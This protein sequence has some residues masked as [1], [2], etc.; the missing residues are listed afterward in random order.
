MDKAKLLSKA[1]LQTAF[2]M[3][4][5]DKSGSISATEL[6]AMLGTEAMNSEEW[7]DIIAEVDKNG[8]GEIDVKEF[9]AI[10]LNKC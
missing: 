1:N 4:D 3:F 10:L 8:D 7:A 6:D 5:T 9:E 2:Q